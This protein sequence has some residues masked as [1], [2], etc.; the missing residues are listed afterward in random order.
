MVLLIYAAVLLAMGRE[1]LANR[2]AEIAY[3]SL[4]VGVIVMLKDVLMEEESLK[5]PSE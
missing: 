5:E 4:V 1:A 2:Y 3:Y